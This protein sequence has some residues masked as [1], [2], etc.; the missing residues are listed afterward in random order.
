MSTFYRSIVDAL[1]SHAM[2]SAYFDRVGGVEPKSSP[3][4]GLSCAVWLDS[5]RT[6]PKGSGLNSTAWVV[7]VNVRLY[8][9]AS[10]GIDADLIDPSMMDAAD[11]LMTAYL[12]DLE[13]GGSAR[14]VDVRGMGSSGITMAAGFIVIDTKQYRVLTIVVPVIC[15]QS[16]E[17]TE[18]P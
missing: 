17:W 14:N 2:A 7:S 3:G 9:P 13:L 5:L 4:R 11:E 16:D 12:G 10:Q 8:T 6:Y 1:Q 18:A 15:K